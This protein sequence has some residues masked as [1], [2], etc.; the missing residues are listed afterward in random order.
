MVPLSAR[1]Q[2]AT[3]TVHTDR[4]GH[5]VSRYLT[6]ACLEDVNHE[7]YGGLYSQMLYGESFQEPGQSVPPAGFR[8][9]GGSW[10]VSG[11]ELHAAA[12]VLRLGRHRHN[13]TLLKDTPCEVPVGRWIP[14]TVKMAAHALEVFVSGKSVVRFDD[15]DQP[16]TSGTVG[17]RPWER[18]ARF[19]N[20]W[21]K[22]GE[23]VEPLPF[24]ATSD[25]SGEVS[26][27]WCVLKRGA[28]TGRCTLERDCAFVGRQSQHLA[29]VGGEGEFG[30]ENRGLNRWGLHVEGG[31]PYQGCV[32]LKAS[33]A[34]DL[35]VALETG[36]GGAV[37]AE[38]KLEVATHDWQRYDFSLT[39]TST[40]DGARLALKLK[41][42]AAV[43]V[44]Y[45]FLRPGE[46]GRTKGC[47]CGATWRRR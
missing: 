21:V 16:L 11:G 14:L 44:G 34:A 15:V 25:D 20:L 45:A 1:G 30:I 22:T 28:A 43:S 10:R 37:L 26:G 35:F 29:F 36:D 33:P 47:R 24:A 41:R 18:G 39:P 3:I 31:K 2:E 4:P 17:L 19:R 32:V 38:E 8:A 5:V 23:A 6:G 13:W 27:M 46:W 42:P 7:V 9:S 12:Q 40:A